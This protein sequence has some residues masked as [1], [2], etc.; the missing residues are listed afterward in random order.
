M[1]PRGLVIAE[2]GKPTSSVGSSDKENATVLLTTNAVGEIV[3][4]LLLLPYQRIPS[5]VINAIPENWS[6]G[7]TP[8]GWMTSEAF[9][10]YIFNVFYQYLIEN[11]VLL[12]VIVVLDGHMSCKLFTIAIL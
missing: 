6:F 5:T 9:Y 11:N 12:P 4:R 1:C 8:L 3:T 7:K 10:E 2:R